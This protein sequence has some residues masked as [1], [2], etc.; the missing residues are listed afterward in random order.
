MKP[1]EAKK[2]TEDTLESR[3]LDGRAVL[4]LHFTM[5]VESLFKH[6]QQ[7]GGGPAL[8]LLQMEPATH[9]DLFNS[10]LNYTSEPLDDRGA[11]TLKTDDRYAI[12]CA[13][14]QYSR[15]INRWPEDIKGAA[16]V[17][18]YDWNT[19]L[20]AG[21][22]KDAIDKYNHLLAEESLDGELVNIEGVTASDYE[23]ELIND[24]PSA[25]FKDLN[26]ETDRVDI[27]QE[28]EEE[29]EKARGKGFW[30]KVRQ[31]AK[32][33]DIAVKVIDVLPVSSGIKRILRDLI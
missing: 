23:P 31:W 12:L 7:I 14:F 28:A 5:G 17:W 13:Y 30:G 26:Y 19:Y 32:D 11:Y 33:N 27:P 16:H 4:L 3:N 15:Y 25:E 18:K 10:Y 20:G 21:N 8:G 9:D 29:Y 1:S 22:I 2:L 24:E 6:R